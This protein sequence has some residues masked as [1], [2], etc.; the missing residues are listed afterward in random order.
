MQLHLNAHVHNY[1]TLVLF[2]PLHSQSR[3]SKS[4]LNVKE[5][6]LTQSLWLLFGLYAVVQIVLIKVLLLQKHP[7]T[8]SFLLHG[9]A[10]H[11][12]HTPTH[13]NPQYVST[14]D[15]TTAAVFALVSCSRGERFLPQGAD[16]L[17][18]EALNGSKRSLLPFHVLSQSEYLLRFWHGMKTKHQRQGNPPFWQNDKRTFPELHLNPAMNIQVNSGKSTLN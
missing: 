3:W 17:W 11:K 2:T 18:P 14:D 6:S 10:L 15:R 4:E 13:V 9:F 16:D 5:L 12:M 1:D 8:S 7:R